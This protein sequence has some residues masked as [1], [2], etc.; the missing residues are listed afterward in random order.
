[1]GKRAPQQ[2]QASAQG[3]FTLVTYGVGMML[4]ARAS[5]LVA[6]HY[7]IV[8]NGQ[9]TG[10]HWTSIWLVPA[11]MAVA[12]SVFLGLFFRENN[13]PKESN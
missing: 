11:I 4:G 5:G 9:I 7:Q 3:L 8:E 1:V 12:V 2:I 10:H 13:I 6:E